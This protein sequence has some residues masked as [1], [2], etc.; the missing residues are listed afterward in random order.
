MRP[1][2][3]TRTDTLLPYTTLFRSN[4]SLGAA[5]RT[6]GGVNGTFSG[7]ISGTGGLTQVGGGTQVLSGCN[8]TYTGSTEI[9]GGAISV[10]C[11][12]DGGQAS[13]IGASSA[14]AGNIVIRDDGILN[15]TGLDQTTD[16]GI[17]LENRWGYVDEIGRAQVCTP[18]TN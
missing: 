9:T 4:V 5:R 8:N 1:P 12:A 17:L 18:D 3:S 6:T 13:G 10:D 15:Y 14:A 11:L 16:S 7:E 2:S